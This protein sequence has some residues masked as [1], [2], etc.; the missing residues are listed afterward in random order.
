MWNWLVSSLML[1]STVCL[2]DGSPFYPNSDILWEYAEKEKFSF[3]GTSAKYIDA[4]SKF[5]NKIS[6]KFSLENLE[7]IGSTGSPLVHESFDYVYNN[8]KKDIHL[9]SL[10]GGTDI[11]GCFVGG[12]PISPVYRGEIQGPILGMDVHV[13][14]DDGNSIINKQGEL[15]CIK[16]F[17]TMPIEFWRDNGEKYH[18]AYFDKYKNVW[19]HGDYILKTENNGFIIF[20]RSDATLNPGGVRIGTAEIYRQVEKID[21]VIE[22]LVI[23]QKWKNDTRLILFVVLRENIELTGEL[24]KI[25]KDQLRIGASP[26]HVPSII[27][28]TP[29]IP[30][31]K[32]GKIVELAVRD[33]VNGKEIKNASALANQECLDFFR[34]LKI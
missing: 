23:G 13:F 12:N 19:N 7:A 8:I 11:V 22:S 18:N 4:L 31:T 5:K 20:G 16:S 9:A 17:P 32:S 24:I 14:D 10:S 6:E 26:R 3:F 33:L 29:E 15:V 1:N 34:N 21:E 30:K 2:Y 28:Q 25:I 27:V